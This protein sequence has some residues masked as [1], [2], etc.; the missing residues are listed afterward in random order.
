MA[1]PQD[2]TDAHH[3]Q[4]ETTPLALDG[5]FCDEESFEFEECC[6]DAETERCEEK[7]SPLPPVLQE[8]DLF[9]DDN[10]LLSLICKEKKENFVPSDPISDEILIL[11]RKE[12][13]EWVLRV[14]AHFGFTAL[15]AILAVNYFDRFI[16]SHSFQKDK[17]WMGQLVAVACLSLAAKVDETQ[18]P[19]LL[20][21][22]VKDPK[23]VFEAKTIQRMELLV[24]STLQWRMNPVTPISFFDHIVRRLGLKTHLHWEF[25]YRCEHLLLSVIAD[26]RFM[27]YLPSTL[28]TATMLHTIQEVEPCNPVE[29]QNLLM[30]V[31]NISQDKL[32]ECYLLILELSRGNG[33]QN[34]SCKRKHFPLPGSS[35][36]IIDANFSCD[37]SND[38]WPA[39]SP[40]SSPPEPRFK[41]SRIHVQQMRLPS[42]TRTFVDV[43]SSPR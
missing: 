41:R 6:I 11:A 23:Y 21:L 25:L 22:Q 40:F 3:H 30:G 4:L 10:E 35:S 14:K 13:V 38:S 34:Q 31:L 36:C 33:S 28:A 18:V 1:L 17:P 26:S 39:A 32:K 27:C 5:L 19:L 16:L 7:E 12:V 29:H 37:S 9:W 8:H 15:T 2:N 24:L 43:L 42:L 20:D